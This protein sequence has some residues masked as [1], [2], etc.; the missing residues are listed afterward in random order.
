MLR[1]QW[2]NLFFP[3]NHSIDIQYDGAPISGS[4]F[5]TKA[6]DPSAIVI[7]NVPSGVVGKP[8]EFTSKSKQ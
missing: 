3:G 7:G 2:I 6:Y 5:V 1:D 4:P 8:V